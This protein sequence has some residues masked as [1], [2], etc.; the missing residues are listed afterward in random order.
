[1]KRMFAYSILIVFCLCC[2]NPNY[3]SKIES[4]L[5]NNNYELAIKWLN[6]A[7]QKD[8]LYLMYWYQR[9]DL[10]MKTQKYKNALRDYDKLLRL[11]HQ[12]KGEDMVHMDVSSDSVVNVNI[13]YEKQLAAYFYLNKLD[14]AEK[15]LNQLHTYFNYYGFLGKEYYWEGMIAWKRGKAGEAYCCFL[16]AAKE[17]YSKASAAIKELGE[18]TGRPIIDPSEIDSTGIEI[19][20][21]DNTKWLFGRRLN[22]PKKLIK[23]ERKKIKVDYVA[24]FILM[25]F[26]DANALK[27]IPGMKNRRKQPAPLCNVYI[28]N[29]IGLITKLPNSKQ[30]SNT[31]IEKYNPCLDNYIP[32]DRPLILDVWVLKYKDSQGNKTCDLYII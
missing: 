24:E 27:Y 17:G 3:D 18:Q 5:Q 14:S 21:T 7:I 29:R 12:Q 6:R 20:F 26:L 11:H 2:S 30:L 19:Q 8:S 23:I 4:A 31:S 28:Y 13:I 10:E 1:M 9:A 22:F 32:Q 16:N 15:K 25:N